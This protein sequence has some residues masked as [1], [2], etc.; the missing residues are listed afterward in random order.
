MTNQE[1]QERV[2]AILNPALEALSNL[3]DEVDPEDLPTSG[4]YALHCIIGCAQVD[5][6]T[7]NLN[8]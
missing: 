1:L 2:N 6:T 5:F 8:I 7:A 4:L 3:A